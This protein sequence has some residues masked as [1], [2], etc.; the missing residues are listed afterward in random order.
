M[1]TKEKELKKEI[2]INLPNLY[3]E[4]QEENIPQLGLWNWEQE[5]DAF[6][7]YCYIFGN[8][9]AKKEFKD[10]VEKF[11]W[12]LA[13]ENATYYPDN[14]DRPVYIDVD[15]IKKELLKAL[16]EKN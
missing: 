10:A 15:K 5:R 12:E 14:L 8:K 7:I 16:E 3:K 13:K 6:G 11:N 2:V 4:F 9:E 1:N